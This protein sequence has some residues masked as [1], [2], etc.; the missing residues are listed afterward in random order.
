MRTRLKFASLSSTAVFSEL[1]AFYYQYDGLQVSKIVARTAVNENVDADIYGLEGE[2]VVTRCD[3]WDVLNA[4]VTLGAFPRR[5][6]GG[7]PRPQQRAS[8]FKR[9]RRQIVAQEI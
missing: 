8:L 5:E 6:R 9:I 4:Q 1:S 2:F 7:E 3:S